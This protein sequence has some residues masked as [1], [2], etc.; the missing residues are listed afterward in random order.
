MAGEIVTIVLATTN[1]AKLAELGGLLRELPVGVVPASEVGCDPNVLDVALASF[2]ENAAHKARAACAAT[3]MLAL[4]DDAGLEVDALGGRPGVRS[5]RFAS[6]RATDAE[7]NAALL[8]EL[9]DVDDPKRRARVRCVLALASPWHD[10]LLV[11]EGRMEGRI[12]RAPQGSGGFGYDSLFVVDDTGERSVA[13]LSDEERS[14]VSHRTRAVAELR[15][16][17]EALLRRM[18]DESER[19]AG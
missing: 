18:L 8:R 10:Q 6:E 7:N 5:A 11:A 19:I 15:P 4:A 13:E 9:E 14:R 17:L 12:A 16:E 2:E 1:E 3:G